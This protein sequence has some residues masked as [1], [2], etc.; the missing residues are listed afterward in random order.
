MKTMRAKLLVISMLISVLTF[1]QN[2]E[3]LS[4]SKL[5]LNL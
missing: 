1:S 3:N 4:Y 5:T 2:S